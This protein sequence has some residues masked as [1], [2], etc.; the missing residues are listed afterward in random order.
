MARLATERAS[1]VVLSTGMER[2]GSY[3][4]WREGWVCEDR[5]ENRIGGQNE[6]C[7][8]WHQRPKMDIFHLHEIYRV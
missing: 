8:G 1:S 2:H 5:V 6:I 7:M 3:A 4:E